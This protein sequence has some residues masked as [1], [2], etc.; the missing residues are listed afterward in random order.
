MPF[1][2]MLPTN[3]A[4]HGLNGVM[5]HLHLDPGRSTYSSQD[6]CWPSCNTNQTWQTKVIKSVGRLVADH[7]STP[8]EKSCIRCWRVWHAPAHC[9]NPHGVG[10]IANVSK[11]HIMVLQPLAVYW[12]TK[13]GRCA[14]EGKGLD[15]FRRW[16]DGLQ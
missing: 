3:G 1:C 13:K 14:L 10:M 2:R 11:A 16:L 8:E 12:R 4:W 6:R 9:C 5:V 15:A 7:I